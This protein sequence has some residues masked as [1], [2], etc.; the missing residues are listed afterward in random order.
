MNT[1]AGV[2]SPSCLFI[3]RVYYACA[4]VRAT[5][6]S[7]SRTVRPPAA[8]P[9]PTK[10]FAGVGG[11]PQASLSTRA[12]GGLGL[13]EAVGCAPCD[14]ASQL[15]WA[16][17]FTSQLVPNWSTHMPKVSPQGAFSKGIVTVPFSLSR[18]Q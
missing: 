17:A 3:T 5:M 2:G 16:E 8:R 13:F 1:F 15:G 11:G 6:S 14:V 9:N 18:S 4:R 10:A 7:D 12:R